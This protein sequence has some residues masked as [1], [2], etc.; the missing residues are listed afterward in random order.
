MSSLFRITVTS[1][2]SAATVKGRL[3]LNPSGFAPDVIGRVASYIEAVA[4]GIHTGRLNIATSAVQ[5]SGTVT[6]SSVVATDTVTIGATVFTGSN[7]S[8]GTAQFRTGGTDTTAAASLAAVINA[9]A[10]TSQ[11]VTATSAGAIVTVTAQIPGLLGNF[12]PIAISAHGS[13]SGSGKLTSGAEDAAV[14][15]YNGI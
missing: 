4:G 7:S 3:R 14:V 5:A 6:F 9:N 11:L 1:G 15:L 2:A 13:V 10:T 12:F 8:S